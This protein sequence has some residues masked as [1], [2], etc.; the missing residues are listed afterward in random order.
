MRFFHTHYRKSNT[1]NE[2]TNYVTLYVNNLYTLHNEMVK[3]CLFKA[4]KVFKK[5][6]LNY[7]LFKIYKSS[8]DFSG[9]LPPKINN[10]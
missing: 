1:I 2:I 9:R 6:F 7:F 4:K 5:V 3:N 10:F 8:D